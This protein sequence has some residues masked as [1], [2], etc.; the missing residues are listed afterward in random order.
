MT[1]KFEKIIILVEQLLQKLK[2]LP[3]EAALIVWL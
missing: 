3:R 1:T 2:E